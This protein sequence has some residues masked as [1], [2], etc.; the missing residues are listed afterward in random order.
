MKR[1]LKR[2]AFTIV[3]MVIVIAVIGILA[4]VMV[5]T[6]SG[7]I[8]K[9]N[10]GADRQFAANLTIQLAMESVDGGIRNESDLRDAVNKCYGKWLDEEK[11][12]LDPD[13]G[14]YYNEKLVP[15]SAKSGNY[16]WYDY[17]NGTV[18]VGTVEEAAEKSAEILAPPAAAQLSATPRAAAMTGTFSPSSLR[19][20]LVEGMYL[21]GCGGQEGDLVDIISQFEGMNATYLGSDYQDAIAAMYEL[22]DACADLE[23]TDPEKMAVEAFVG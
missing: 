1:F 11:T 14:D 16:F 18:F 10:K 5:P 15:K 7:M 6:I 17:N 22:Q 4:T 23:A 20:D 3:E 13:G 9:A 21:M 8:E 2:S 19:S 12:Q